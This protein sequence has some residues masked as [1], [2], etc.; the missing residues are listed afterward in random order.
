MHLLQEPSFWPAYTSTAAT[1]TSKA[2][3]YIGYNRSKGGCRTAT[4]GKGSKGGVDYTE[5]HLDNAGCKAKCNAHASCLG[6]EVKKDQYR[7]ISK[8]AKVGGCELWHTKPHEQAASTYVST[9]SQYECSVK[10]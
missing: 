8:G 4:Q 5:E 7:T 9:S 1:A 3:I 2:K 6:F 10:Q